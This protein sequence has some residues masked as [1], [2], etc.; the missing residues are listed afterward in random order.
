MKKRLGRV[1]DKRRRSVIIC[2]TDKSVIFIEIYKYLKK[3]WTKRNLSTKT[4]AISR[5]ITSGNSYL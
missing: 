1:Y 2:D 5:R 4:I 3:H